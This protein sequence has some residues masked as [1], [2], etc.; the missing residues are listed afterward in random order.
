MSGTKFLTSAATITGAAVS[1]VIMPLT[2]LYLHRMQILNSFN[3]GM[4][5]T[6]KVLSYT[7]KFREQ[8]R[9]YTHFFVNKDRKLPLLSK[10][11]EYKMLSNTLACVGSVAAFLIGAGCLYFSLQNNTQINRRFNKP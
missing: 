4:E 5:L 9:K 10:E 7:N 3:K 2:I 8:S 11:Q 1:S 6:K